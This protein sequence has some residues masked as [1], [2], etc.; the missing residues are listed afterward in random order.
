MI[1]LFSTT[2]MSEFP[3]KAC[4]EFYALK[5]K[6]CVRNEIFSVSSQDYKSYCRE[7]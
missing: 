1:E 6:H 5:F 2:S 4:C 7:S 3:K